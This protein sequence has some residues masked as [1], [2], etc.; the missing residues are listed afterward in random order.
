MPVGRG[1][2]TEGRPSPLLGRFL[3]AM[4]RKQGVGGEGVSPL[5]TASGGDGV[6]NVHL[7]EVVEDKAEEGEEVAQELVASG[8][9]E[10]RGGG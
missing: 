4:G 5:D 1:V 2:A 3:G 8:L 10:R 6:E 9:I 7:G